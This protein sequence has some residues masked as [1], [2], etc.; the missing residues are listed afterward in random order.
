MILRRG[1][2]ILISL[3]LLCIVAL[4]LY[5]LK[6]YLDGLRDAP[7]LAARADRLIDRGQGAEAL[8]GAERLGWLIT[9]QDPGFYDHNGVD[10]QTA[11]AGITTITQSLSKREAFGQ[12]QPGIGKLRQTTYALALERRLSKDQILALFL[13]TVEMGPGPEGWMTGFG[14]ASETVFGAAPADLPD[15]DMMR[16][17]AVMIAPGRFNLSEPGPQLNTRI[18]R[19]A[20]RLA[21]AC[22]PQDN[23]DVWLQGCAF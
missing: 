12:F 18:D 15:R 10:M 4:G 21:G 22:V 13:E 1:A 6:G 11:G 20:R 2:I 8:L 14:H 9:V 23:R 3:I 5:G 16:L 19:I 7:A 17:L